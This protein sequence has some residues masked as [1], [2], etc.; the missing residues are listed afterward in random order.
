MHEDLVEHA[1]LLVVQA[2]GIAQEKIGDATKHVD[3]FV[4]RANPQDLVELVK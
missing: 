4:R 2:I 1:D 3:A